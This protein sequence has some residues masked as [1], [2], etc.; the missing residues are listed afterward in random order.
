MGS[1]EVLFEDIMKF[2]KEVRMRVQMRVVVGVFVNDAEVDWRR[3]GDLYIDDASV[4][5]RGDVEMQRVT[6]RSSLGGA[7]RVVHCTC[8]CQSRSKGI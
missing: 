8:Q 7:R 1:E 6:S 4:C 2:V 5:W 3:G